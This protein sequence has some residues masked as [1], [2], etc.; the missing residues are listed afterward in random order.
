MSSI[1]TKTL[2][3]LAMKNRMFRSRSDAALRKRLA[4]PW[5]TGRIR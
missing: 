2:F 3:D 5:R 1:E 4:S